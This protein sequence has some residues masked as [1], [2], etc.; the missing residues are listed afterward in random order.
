MC[1]AIS[2]CGYLSIVGMINFSYS[3]SLFRL[4]PIP[5]ITIPSVITT[6]L[7]SNSSIRLPALFN[8]IGYTGLSGYLMTNLDD[9]NQD[10]YFPGPIGY[11]AAST[12]YVKNALNGY[13]NSSSSLSSSLLSSG[14]NNS[15]IGVS[16]L[17]VLNQINLTYPSTN[18]PAV[19]Y[20]SGSPGNPSIV[21]SART[22]AP[23][24]NSDN[25]IDSVGTNTISMRA[26]SGQL[27]SVNQNFNSQKTITAGL[28][29]STNGYILVPVPTGV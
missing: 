29:V 27:V 10:A 5:T 23:Q 3:S 8:N 14:T 11:S 12:K 21:L 16:N 1:L 17:T 2:T 4:T 22:G 9:G 26:N 7:S 19:I 20:S 6:T 13:L 15:T 28:N 25:Y 18:P 24:F